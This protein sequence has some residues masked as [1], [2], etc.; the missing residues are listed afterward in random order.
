MRYRVC[1]AAVLMATLMIGAAW[2]C[3]GKTLIFE[4]KFQDD[5]G[6]WDKEPAMKIEDGSMV[7]RPTGSNGSLSELNTAFLATDVDVCAEVVLPRE[8]PETGPTAGLLFW[9]VDYSNMYLSVVSLKG[10][11]FLYRRSNQKWFK[12]WDQEAPRAKQGPGASNLLRVVAKGNLVTVFVNGEKVREVRVQAPSGETRF[13][14]Y[15]E[16]DKPV[17]GQTFAFKNFKVTRP[18]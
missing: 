11:A 18:E 1:S 7:L 9:A 17:E 5:L 15:V 8:F 10:Q 12:I 14:T 16:R 3:E 2:G 6:G 4:D 13:G